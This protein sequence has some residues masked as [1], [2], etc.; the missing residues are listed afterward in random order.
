MS[1]PAHEGRQ[2]DVH[3]VNEAKEDFGDQPDGSDDRSEEAAM[4]Y[5]KFADLTRDDDALDRRCVVAT[6][7]KGQVQLEQVEEVFVSSL[8][9][10][11]H[12]PGHAA[13][14]SPEC[15]SFGSAVGEAAHLDLEHTFDQ[16]VLDHIGEVTVHLDAVIA[17]DE[18]FRFAIL[19]LPF[20]SSEIVIGVVGTSGQEALSHCD[21]KQ[22]S[23]DKENLL[24]HFLSIINTL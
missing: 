17:G 16:S 22:G 7:G 12:F 13:G 19:V 8:D 18:F 14:S 3:I 2:Q 23:C 15:H 4:L 24:H 9:F 21:R 1:L 20:V 6:S 5:H 10:L 11:A